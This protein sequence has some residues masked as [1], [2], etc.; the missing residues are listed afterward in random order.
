MLLGTNAI[1]EPGSFSTRTKLGRC[2][3]PV[4]VYI[5]SKFYR[6]RGIF[7]STAPK[8]RSELGQFTLINFSHS[9]LCSDR[10]DLSKIADISVK[11]SIYPFYIQLLRQIQ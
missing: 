6:S 5:V 9:R 1:S 4:S 11:W 7:A 2:L 10:A 8:A 3:N